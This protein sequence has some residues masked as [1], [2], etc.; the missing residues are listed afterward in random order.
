VRHPAVCVTALEQALGTRY[1]VATVR[2]LRRR[3]P[4]AAFVW[5]MGADNLIQV[6][7]W[8]DWGG[9]FHSI[10]I[11]VLARPSYSLRAATGKAAQRFARHRLR[12]SE[13]TTLAD[14][15]P[16]AWVFLR[17]PLHR[18]SGTRLRALGRHHHDVRTAYGE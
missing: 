5:L 12:S 18:E 11:A 2:A 16:P 17:I 8:R 13:A 9:L 10:P 3:F 4:R 1:T 6:P 15:A 14:A 7:R